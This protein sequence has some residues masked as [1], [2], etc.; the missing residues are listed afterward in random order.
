MDVHRIPRTCHACRADTDAVFY[1]EALGLYACKACVADVCDGS[2]DACDHG[3]D[4]PTC[5]GAGETEPCCDHDCASYSRCV[6]GA[7]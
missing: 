6:G 4:S 5:F 7:S 1:C 3:M 2:C